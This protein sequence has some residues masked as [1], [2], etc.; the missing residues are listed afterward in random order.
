[1]CRGGLGHFAVM[2]AKALGAEVYVISHSPSKKSDAL[3]MGAKHFIVN[4]RDDWAKPYAFMFD[5]ILNT[6]DM[7]HKFDLPQ[8][9]STLKVEGKFHNVGMPDEPISLK[10][11]D[12]AS[13]GCYIGTSHI[14]NRQEMLD[15]LDLASKQ[16]IKSWVE[17]IPISEAGCKEAVERVKDNKARY[18]ITLVEFDVAF[19]TRY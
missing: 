6:A 17:V 14:G 10:L 12:F 9:F 13:N 18:R 15:M 19:G 11:Q 1:M 5:F 4:D 3:K 2:F 8:Y 7:T 16:N